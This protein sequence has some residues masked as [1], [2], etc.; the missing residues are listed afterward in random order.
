M[1]EVTRHFSATTY[2]VSNKGVLLHKH[3]KLNIWLPVGGHI[4][5]DELPEDA[6]IREVKEETGLDVDL[7]SPNELMSTT[8][9]RELIRPHHMMLHNLNPFHQHI[10]MVFFAQATSTNFNVPEGESNNLK[11]FT[12]QDLENIKGDLFEDVLKIAGSVIELHHQI[13]NKS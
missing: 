9:G 10:D 3:K 12:K 11:W 6:A 13:N 5:R 1:V 8:N 2:V 7:I 4:D